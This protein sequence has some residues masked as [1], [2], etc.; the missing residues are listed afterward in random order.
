MAERFTLLDL[1]VDGY[2][3]EEAAAFLLEKLQAGEGGY[4][5]TLN[6]EM[7]MAA[8]R[9]EG[10]ARVIRESLLCVPDGVGIVWAGRR[11][12]L[13]PLQRVAGIDL[14]E[15]LLARLDASLPVFLLGG[16]PGVAAEAAAALQKKFPD[17]S[18]AGV[19]HGYFPLE[20]GP[21]LAA[22]IEASGAR[23]LIL[24]MGTPKEQEFYLQVKEGLASLVIMG[25]GGALDV[26]SGRLSRAPRFWQR[27]G[28]EWLYRL[29][30]HPS[31]LG[32]QRALFQFVRRVSQSSRTR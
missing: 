20:H 12:G 31:R 11:L 32:R 18:V 29:L 24:G 23:L 9:H 4:V 5:A 19:H 2:S 10:V 15:A 7:A 14:G 1:P 28:L 16:K 17:L 22:R 21:A 3:L 26:W 6:P 25:L 30:R 27:L 8:L 13:P